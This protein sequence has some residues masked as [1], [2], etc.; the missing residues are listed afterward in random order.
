MIFSQAFFKGGRGV[1]RPPILYIDSDS[2]AFKGL[3]KEAGTSRPAPTSLKIYNF[4]SST[5]KPKVHFGYFVK[6]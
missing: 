3:F 2:P 5:L 6:G 1:G 4:I